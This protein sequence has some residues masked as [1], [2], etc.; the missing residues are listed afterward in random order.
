VKSADS[1]LD[2][3]TG[4]QYEFKLGYR[5]RVIFRKLS[6]N[7]QGIK[8]VGVQFAWGDRS[9]LDAASTHQIAARRE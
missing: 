5:R 6:R 2:M 4:L 1:L 9:A 8:Y 7:N 3:V